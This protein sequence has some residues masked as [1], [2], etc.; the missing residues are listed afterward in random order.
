[1]TLMT[2]VERVVKR[3]ECSSV[4]APFLGVTVNPG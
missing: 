3:P 2:S 4:L 1:M